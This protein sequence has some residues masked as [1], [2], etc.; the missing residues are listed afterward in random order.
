[1]LF[2]AVSLRCCLGQEDTFL[3]K[4]KLEELLTDSGFIEGLESGGAI[5]ASPVFLWI[6]L[7]S[8]A[9]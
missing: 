8:K 2:L 5:K 1:M 7:S 4:E 9:A 6:L 3:G